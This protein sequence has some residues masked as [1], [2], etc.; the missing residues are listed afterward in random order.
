MHFKEYSQIANRFHGDVR[1]AQGVPYCIAAIE[2]YIAIGSS[3][4]SI[5]LFDSKD[6]VE[7]KSLAIKEMKLNAVCSLDIKR[8]RGENLIHAVAG[9]SK[10]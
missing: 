3:D 5:R 8:T 1:V 4:G 9:H 7:I 6:E 10:G 2:N